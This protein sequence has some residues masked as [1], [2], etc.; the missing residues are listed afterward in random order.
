MA[1]AQSDALLQ[2]LFAHC[3]QD[4]FIYRHQWQVGDTVIWDNRRLMHNAEPY[5]MQRYT[6]HMHRTS[7]IGDKPF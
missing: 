4:R 7:I 2:D 5:D 1:T 3:L 6:R